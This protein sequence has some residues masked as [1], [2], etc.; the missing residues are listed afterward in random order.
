MTLDISSDHRLASLW[1]FSLLLLFAVGCA[2]EP[3]SA[4]LIEAIPILGALGVALTRKSVGLQL[5]A[6]V[7]TGVW[8]VAILPIPRIWP[9]AQLIMLIPVSL[10]AWKFRE[11]IDV[12]QWLQLGAFQALPVLLIGCLAVIALPTWFAL[13][14]ADISDATNMLPAWPVS[15]LVVAGLVFSVCNAILEEILFR[16]LLQGAL[17]SLVSSIWVPIIFQGI[18]FGL[19]H[20]HGF[21]NG[22]VGVCL[23]GIWGTGLGWARERSNGLL[24]PTLGHM[25]ADMVIFGIVYGSV[26]GIF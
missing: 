14:Q 13:T 21:P 8:M 26:R 24:T 20:W 10:G 2:V 23:S 25:V 12:R 19:L 9:L 17:K 15:L 4:S 18:A 3:G 11:T 1:L 5:T 7:V 22:A 6:L 16:G